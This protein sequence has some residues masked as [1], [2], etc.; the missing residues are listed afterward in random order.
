LFAKS[1]N[2]QV[3][4]IHSVSELPKVGKTTVTALKKLGITTIHDLLFYFPYRYLDFSQFKPISDVKEGE[5]VTIRGIVKTIQSRFSFRGRMS[6][7]EAIV[8]DDTGSI[9]IVWFNQPYLAKSIS[10]G[11]DIL[12]SGKVTKYGSLQLQ[13][14][15]YERFNEDSTHT[16]RLVPVYHATENLYNRTIRTLVKT[17]LPLTE[18]VEDI[19]PDS[20]LQ[21]YDLPSLSQ[22]INEL[23]FPSN[24][25]ALRA[26]QR[27]IIFDEVLIQQLAVQMHKQQ[28]EASQATSI[29]AN[30]T[31][32][33]EFLSS[34]PF[35]LTVGQKKALWEIMQDM[36]QSS[37]MNRLLE[38]DVGSGKTLVALLACLETAAAGFQAVML[39]P[40]EI[41]A[42]QHYQSFLNYLQKY[43]YPVA[44]S[45]RNFCLAN[46]QNLSKTNFKRSITEGDI[47]IIIGTHTLLQGQQFPKLGLVII[48]EQHRFGVSQRSTLLKTSGRS[49]PHLLSMTATPIPRTLALSIY[50]D[51]SISELK[52]LPGGRQPI[53]TK[54]VTEED[55]PKAYEFI[56]EQLK[57]GRQAFI[58]TPRVEESEA[59]TIKSAK[60]ELTHLQKQVFPTFRLGLIH[61]K[62]TGSEKEQ[63]M[64]EF[65]DGS[66][67]IL[68]ATS[69]IE[70]GIDVPNATV[71]VIEDAERFG[72]AQLH[73]L[74]GRVG[75]GTHQSYCLLFT[76]AT[77]PKTMERLQLFSRIHDGFKLAELDLKQRGFGSLFGLQQS[78]FDFK[79][80]QYLT[81][82]VLKTGREAAQKL[83]QQD[84]N[85]RNFP[86]LK[87][88][89]QPL[90]E[91]IH[92]E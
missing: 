57:A 46:N 19:I 27:R 20:L 33:K 65:N 80:S 42:Q 49:R 62:M 85:L 26:A 88:Q 58:V 69:V 38:G 77:E 29:P 4:L 34:L 31:L 17:Y 28:L 74:R 1:Y 7:A 78:G 40:T 89:V 70:I 45:T 11:D 44:L 37:P 25:E 91:Q 50:S 67:D 92:L 32:V 35:K 68:V 51:L 54:V 47:K 84:K 39:A 24:N 2:Y 63:I 52:E 30:V 5:T 66:I 22:S 21:E 15:I 53:T 41:L 10:K 56:K 86:K 76:Q 8:S 14:P 12:L 59:S 79:F 60:Q 90:L 6:L 36:E 75:R 13:N 55:R 81:L 87:Q 9:K 3:N 83:L 23:H 61:G 64:S 16:G 43:P 73:Q 72:L 18:Q 71:I 48:D 82:G